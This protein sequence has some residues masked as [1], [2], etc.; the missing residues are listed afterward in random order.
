MPKVLAT[1]SVFMVEKL[2]RKEHACGVQPRAPGIA[3]QEDGTVSFGAP[4]RG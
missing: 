1:P 3:F 2:S 4:V